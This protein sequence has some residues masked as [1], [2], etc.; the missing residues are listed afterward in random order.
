VTLALRFDRGW[1]KC[2]PDLEGELACVP[3]NK[4]QEHF[5]YPEISRSGIKVEIDNLRWSANRNWAE[6]LGIVL[7]VVCADLTGLSV[8]SSSSRRPLRQNLVG[9]SLA[10]NLVQKAM[11]TRLG[12]FV[13]LEVR[14]RLSGL[15][16]P[17]VEKVDIGLGTGSLVVV[18]GNDVN[19]VQSF[20][21][22]HDG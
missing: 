11:V 16:T 17:F 9:C 13:H 15:E 14:T 20:E 1:E 5:T 12:Y 10:T 19:L 22:S 21:A 3:L 2:G 4:K 7:L 18:V 8:S 6:V